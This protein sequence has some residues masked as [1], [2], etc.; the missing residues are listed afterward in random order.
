MKPQFVEHADKL[1][2]RILSKYS[3]AIF[4]E[5]VRQHV[6]QH[7]SACPDAIFVEVVRQH[8]TASNTKKVFF[9][10]IRKKIV[11]IHLHKKRALI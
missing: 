3:A 6:R 4:F 1:C 2:C 9:A 10:H 7:S 11:S 8:S 5:D